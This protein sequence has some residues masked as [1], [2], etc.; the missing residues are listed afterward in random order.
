MFKWICDVRKENSLQ[1][2]KKITMPEVKAPRKKTYEELES[3]Y[4]YALEVIEY[5]N[6]ELICLGKKEHADS[7]VECMLSFAGEYNNRKKRSKMESIRAKLTKEEL[8]LIDMKDVFS[9]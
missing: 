9:R 4:E 6:V 2:T 5:L 3:S 8:D 1:K 7:R